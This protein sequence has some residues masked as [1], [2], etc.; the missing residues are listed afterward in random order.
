MV[1]EILSP[2]QTLTELTE[3][4]KAYFSTGVASYWLVVPI[5]RTIY[6]LLP[7]GEELVFHNDIL[8]DPTN[9]ISIDLVKVFR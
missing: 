6:I 1:V 4:A 2:S 9:G 5:L 8:T 7:N 3:K